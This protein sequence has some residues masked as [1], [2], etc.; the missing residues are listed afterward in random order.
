VPYV[1][2]LLK[3][4]EQRG[5]WGSSGDFVR[6][7][8]ATIE[9]EECLMSTCLDVLLQQNDALYRLLNT[10]LLG[11]AYT[12]VSADPLVVTPAIAPHVNLDVHDQDS[13]MGRIDRFTQLLDNSV[14]GT[15]TPL[16]T[17]DPSVKAL[18]Q[19]IIDALGT[20]DTDLGDLLSQLEI[21]AALVA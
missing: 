18:L 3:I 2:G 1:G 10:A 20:E 19:S 6:G 11:V 4:L 7:Y 15:E 17:Y 13:L 14:N 9:L 5:F 21:I 8:T 16:Y 12:T